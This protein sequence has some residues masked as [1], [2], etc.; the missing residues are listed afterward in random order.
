MKDYLLDLMNEAIAEELGASTR[1]M[2]QYAMLKN[3]VSEDLRDN[4]RN[5]ASDSI[6]RAMK[7]GER[8]ISL[9]GDPSP[10]P[11]PINIENSFREM[12]EMDLKSADAV[13]KTYRS[14]V[15]VTNEVEDK[16]THSICKEILGEW[17]EQKRLLMCARGRAIKKV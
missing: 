12:I 2:W 5:N 6:I 15:E 7:V 17:E 8:L 1:Y 16:T 9:G 11:I 3:M 4:L 14:I 10:K 13:I